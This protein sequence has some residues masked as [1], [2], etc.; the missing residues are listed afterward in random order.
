MLE[1]E[2]DEV[3][4]LDLIALLSSLELVNQVLDVLGVKALVPLLRRRELPPRGLLL[5]H[6]M[7]GHLQLVAVFR[8]R[9]LDGVVVVFGPDGLK[10]YVELVLDSIDNLEGGIVLTHDA[11]D[12]VRDAARPCDEVLELI[13]MVCDIGEESIG[14]M[15][16]LLVDVA[17]N[18]WGVLFLHL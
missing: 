5:L 1:H 11:R 8:M 10:V 15:G 7:N 17:L 4:K 12:G 3:S 9:E 14:V 6:E 2:L 13:Q 18:N 16:V